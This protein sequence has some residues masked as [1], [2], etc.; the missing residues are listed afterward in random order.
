LG[1]GKVAAR[2]DMGGDYPISPKPFKNAP[3]K[4]AEV[5]RTRRKIM[6]KGIIKSKKVNKKSLYKVVNK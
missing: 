4:H 1:W 5:A 2:L 3:K 6:K